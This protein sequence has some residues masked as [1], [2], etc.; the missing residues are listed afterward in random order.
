M[1]DWL[2]HIEVL[3]CFLIILLLQGCTAE[4]KM[5]VAPEDTVSQEKVRLELCLQ[6]DYYSLPV[7][8]A[9]LDNENRIETVWVLVFKGTTGAATFIEAAKVE[10]TQPD[11]DP[12]RGWVTLKRQSSACRLLFLANPGVLDGG[13]SQ[14]EDL[15][16]LL[17]SLPDAEKTIQ[18]ISDQI[19]LTPNLDNPQ[20]TAPYRNPDQP[21]PMSR[22]I[23]VDGIGIASQIETSVSLTLERSVAKLTVRRT[24]DIDDSLFKMAGIVAVLNAP[25]Q[26]RLYQSG[27]SLPD[28]AVNRTDYKSESPLFA[29]AEVVGALNNSTE[30]NPVYLYETGEDNELSVILKCS[31]Q[32]EE[33]HYYKIV[34]VDEV[35]V[36]DTDDYDYKP[37]YRNHEYIFTITRASGPGYSSLQAA[38]VSRPSNTNLDYTIQVVD[39]D[40]YEIAANNDYYLGISNSV[41]IVYSSAAYNE[42]DAFTLITNCARDFPATENVIEAKNFWWIPDPPRILLTDPSDAKIPIVSGA[43]SDPVVQPVRIGFSSEINNGADYVYLKLGNLEKEV[44]IRRFDA[45]APQGT[46]ISPPDLWNEFYCFSASVDENAR[47]WIKLARGSDPGDI[48]NDADHLLADNGKLSIHVT[49][50]NGTNERTGIVYIVCSK[51]SNVNDVPDL[52]QHQGSVF[53]IKMVIT[54]QGG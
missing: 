21:L 3:G 34:M 48:R 7:T 40:A 41:F 31:W 51:R 37:V 2:R 30:N 46:V 8:R 29:A 49:E 9:A 18:Y 50:N 45:V 33:G 47:D 16:S 44:F 53:R 6:T 24:N 20:P 39:T 17:H 52:I 12:L 35:N 10:F 23:D 38:I 11:S 5:I 14:L 43:T 15:E 25:R 1:R 22:L 28:P 36:G 26:G 13:I 4:E 19:L 42:L 27:T 32:G 54:Q